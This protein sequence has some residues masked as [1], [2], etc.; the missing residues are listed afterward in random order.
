MSHVQYEAVPVANKHSH[1]GHQADL[2]WK[3]LKQGGGGISSVILLARPYG[4]LFSSNS[5]HPLTRR[6]C[7]PAQATVLCTV[8]NVP[9]YP[10]HTLRYH[11]NFPPPKGHI[12]LSRL[13]S[14]TDMLMLHFRSPYAT[15]MINRSVDWQIGSSRGHPT[16]QCLSAYNQPNI[17]RI[18]LLVFGQHQNQSPKPCQ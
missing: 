10:Y 16:A 7:S 3:R 15:G 17:M 1:Y 2:V 13:A 4:M 14:S 11:G 8:F 6:G 18:R 9:T 5:I 12:L